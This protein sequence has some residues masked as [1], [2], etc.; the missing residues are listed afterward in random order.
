MTSWEDMEQQMDQWFQHLHTHPEISWQEQQTTDYLV[1]EL[2]KLGLQPERFRDMTGLYVDIGEGVPT[3]GIR[4]D[5]DALWQQ[6][7]GEFRANHSCGHDGHM[8]MALGAAWYLSKHKPARAV[9]IIFQPAEEKGTGAKAVV[10]EGVIDELRYL[11]GVHVRPV[12]ELQNGM[13]APAIIHG[14]AKMFSGKITGKQ[15]HGSRPEQAVNAIEVGTAF[16]TALKSLW[17]DPNVSS[18]VKVTQFQ[19]GG[20]SANIIPSDAVFKLDARAVTNDMM[21]QVTEHVKRAAEYAAGLFG[22]SIEVQEDTHVAAAIVSEEAKE[23]MEQAIRKVAGSEHLAPAIITP[24]GEDFHFYTLQ[25]PSLH[26]TMLG[27]GC[28]VTP[29]LHDP[30][31][32]FNQEQLLTGA[33][34]LAEVAERAAEKAGEP[35]GDL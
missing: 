29:G 11:F 32:T 35:H 12:K 30:H 10:N 8:T 25:R 22:A 9:R 14:A 18:S 5:I 16:V 19:A 33:R 26:A 31:M 27:L 17:T 6:V 4:T 3:V 21:E 15:A 23:L 20:E 7:D 1:Q 13:H 28:G 34:I 2:E 24:G